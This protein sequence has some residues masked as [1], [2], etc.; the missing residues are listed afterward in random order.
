MNIDTSRCERYLRGVMA[1]SLR[2]VEDTRVANHGHRYYSPVRHSQEKVH[3]NVQCEIMQGMNANEILNE[4]AVIS[5]VPLSH[6]LLPCGLCGT[7]CSILIYPCANGHGSCNQLK[8]VL[9][10]TQVFCSI[11]VFW[12]LLSRTFLLVLV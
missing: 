10:L 1:H 12:K 7:L 6:S 8:T 5:K 9:S 4:V 3:E 11:Q 2:P